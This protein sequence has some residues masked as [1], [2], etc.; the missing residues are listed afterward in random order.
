MRE[1]ERRVTVD[2]NMC[3]S[4]RERGGGG[5]RILS[6]KSYC[7]YRSTVV[8]LSKLF[9]DVGTAKLFYMS[10]LFVGLGVNG[11]LNADINL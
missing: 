9:P 1:M 10:T 3:V 4:E 6:C 8:L 11:R 5:C 2:R 7:I